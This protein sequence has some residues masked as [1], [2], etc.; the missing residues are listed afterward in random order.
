MFLSKGTANPKV[1]FK[2][3]EIVVDAEG[4]VSAAPALAQ[5][6]GVGGHTFLCLSASRTC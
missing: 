3:S 6:D 1:T 5:A 2:L 4:G